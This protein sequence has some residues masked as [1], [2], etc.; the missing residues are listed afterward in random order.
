[1]P[2]YAGHTRAS[3][4]RYGRRLRKRHH[5]IRR[6]ISHRVVRAREV[7]TEIAYVLVVLRSVCLMPAI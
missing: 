4:S 3:D 7:R 6:W 5:F 2:W 1:M